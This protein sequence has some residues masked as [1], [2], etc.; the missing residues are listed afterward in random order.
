MA[1]IVYCQMPAPR[2]LPQDI[3]APGQKL[4]CKSLRVGA[5][6]R[7]KSPGV[8]GGSS[9][10]RPGSR[11]QKCPQLCTSQRELRQQQQQE[12]SKA[13]CVFLCGD[14]CEAFG[15][16]INAR[17]RESLKTTE[18]TRVGAANI[19]VTH[20][21]ARVGHT[22][23]QWNPTKPCPLLS[24]STS[25]KRLSNRLSEAKVEI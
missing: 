7:C 22:F 16:T 19:S 15:R 1:K 24:N 20:Y 18:W 9:K 11:S 25:L 4:G 17:L 21:G 23:H 14:D 3:P 6:F 13:T 5:N 2:D 10:L 8:R 12:S